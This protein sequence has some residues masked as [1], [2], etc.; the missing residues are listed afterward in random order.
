[1]GVATLPNGTRLALGARDPMSTGVR[2]DLSKAAAVAAECGI[3]LV[4]ALEDAAAIHD[5]LL[6][7]LEKTAAERLLVRPRQLYQSLKIAPD[8]T[9]PGGGK[10]VV[11]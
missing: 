9:A 6:T 7:C 8:T 11:H 10:R 4:C 1:M 5:R 2:N 3:V